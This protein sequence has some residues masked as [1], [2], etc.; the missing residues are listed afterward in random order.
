[1]PAGSVTVTVPSPVS[2]SSSFVARVSVA[3]D[4][5]AAKV[6][7]DGHSD[8]GSA[9]TS[10]VWLTSTVTPVS[11]AA[12]EPVRDSVNTASMPS[13]TVSGV[14]AIVT[15]G[16]PSSS[17]IVP[18]AVAVAVAVGSCTHSG[19]RFDSVTVKVSSSSSASCA[20]ATVNVASVWLVLALKVSVPVAAVKSPVSAVS[21]VASDASQST[22]TSA[23]TFSDSVTMNATASPSS[24]WASA[25]LSIGGAAFRRRR[26]VTVGADDQFRPVSGQV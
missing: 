5:F 20:V 7:D 11:A 3:A 22:V 1:M 13:V 10:P 14:A 21:S 4:A 19:D 18:V 8:S 25:M 17:R 15:L 16:S 12:V 24:A 9:S 2:V 6:T 23:P 26:S